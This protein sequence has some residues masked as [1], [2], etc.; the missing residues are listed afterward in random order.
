MSRRIWG[1]GADLWVRFSLQSMRNGLRLGIGG[2]DGFPGKFRFR[3]IRVLVD[4]SFEHHAG[5]I[6]IAEFRI[7]LP[8]F[9][10]RCCQLW[11]ERIVRD[12]IV[13]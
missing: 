2:I 8:Y 9:Q 13:K 10:G 1:D 11:T 4:Y 7:G 3:T 6:L 5:F 12:D